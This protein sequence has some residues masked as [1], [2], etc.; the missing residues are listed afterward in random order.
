MYV[1]FMF[2]CDVC[3]LRM[4]DIC[5]YICPNVRC[6][7]ISFHLDAVSNKTI[8]FPRYGDDFIFSISQKFVITSVTNQSFCIAI[9]RKLRIS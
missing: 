9:T 5:L 3:I 6:M 7:N 1:V 4:S 8:A 2:V